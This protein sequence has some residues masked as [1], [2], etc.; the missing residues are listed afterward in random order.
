MATSFEVGEPVP[1]PQV[2][3]AQIA[4]EVGPGPDD[5]PS[6]RPGLGATWP[7]CVRARWRDGPRQ[8]VL[9]AAAVTVEPDT[10]LGYSVFTTDLDDEVSLDLEL[11][12][13]TTLS[14]LGARDEHAVPLTP[15]A[16]R[17]MPWPR[18]WN[19]VDCHVGAL[20]AGRTVTA[21][22]VR[23]GPGGDGKDR[24][25]WIDDVVLAPRPVADSVGPATPVAPVDLVDTRRGSRSGVG[26]SRGNTFPAA[27]LPN[28]ATLLS[29]TTVPRLDWF[30]SWSAHDDASGR[31]PLHGL[32]LSHQP[33]PW[34]GD[35]NPLVV[36]L[37]AGRTFRHENETARPHRYTVRLDDG[38]LVDA[39]PTAHGAVVR[40]TA[41]DE[42]GLP[43]VTLATVAGPCVVE[44]D[45]GGAHGWLESGS[46]LSVG[47]SRLFFVVRADVPATWRAD[48]ALD[49]GTAREATLRLATSLI[50]VDQA[51]VNLA[52]EIAD[53]G[54]DEVAAR[55]RG[56]WAERLGV[57][58]IAGASHDELVTA[59]SCLYRLNLYP[60]VPTEL[61]SSV[62]A[63]GSRREVYASPVLPQR[64]SAPERTGA[65]VVE[66]SIAVNHGFWDT[67]RTVWPLY[68]LL[69]PQ[70][71]ARLA[72]GFVEQFRTAGW[73][74]RWSS[75]GF[76][77]LMTGTSSDVALADLD[78]KGVPLPDRVA[79]YRAGLR[80]ATAFSTHPAVGRKD[81][82]ETAYRG[83]PSPRTDEPVS[84]A[85]EGAINDHA[86]AD[87][88]DR[89]AAAPGTG[90]REAARYRD[91]AAYLRHRSAAWVDLFD[92]ATGFFRSRWA[93]GRFRQ[94]PGEYDPRTWGGDYTE[95]DGWA[96]AFP[97]PHDVAGLAALV[98]G[99]DALRA[100]LDA[101]FATPER[102]DR[103]GSYPSAMHELVEAS[104]LRTG[105]F[106]VSNQPVHHVPFLYAFTDAPWRTGEVVHDAL[107]RLF[108]GSAIGQGYPGDED[109]GE[110][111]AWYLFAAT[112]LYPLQVGSPR[113]TLHAPLFDEITW[114]L[115]GGDLVVRAHRG[116][117]DDRYPQRVL[118]DGEEHTVTWIDHA[119]LAGGATVDVELGP[120]PSGWGVGH[121]TD[122]PSL[123]PPGERPRPWRDVSGSGRLRQV[124]TRR[125]DRRAD[126]LLD[127]ERRGRVRLAVGEALLWEGGPA[128][129]VAMYT[130][131]SSGTVDGRAAWRLEAADDGGWLLLDR[132]EDEAF[133]WPDQLRPFSIAHPGVH[134]RYRLVLE[135]AP[136]GGLSLSQ[137]ELLTR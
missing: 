55:A 10:W 131:T 30:Y 4:L 118:V 40:L 49:L 70:V 9:L 80:N 114:H 14:G 137:L 19:R 32:V 87:M 3:G 6:D 51:R 50:G 86:L 24:T 63:D 26:L 113:Y 62:A 28:G 56:A 98:G 104:L 127:D 22:V 73:V 66:G 129:P 21:V 96:F 46:R 95:A 78:A 17:R 117:P 106:A 89:L 115:P 125:R 13:G 58:E 76:A 102:A 101:F 107:R 69:Y 35:R 8:A 119:R 133:D 1:P 29:P 44:P 85:F 33:S 2:P 57:L 15:Q 67:Y 20:A 99:R 37:G 112:G 47:R 71:A 135:A 38:L 43:V 72:D 12:D 64:P 111:S 81:L 52:G 48:G 54:L 75:P 123:T 124:R 27:A 59:Y 132:R 128:E 94:A 23:V 91:E 83:V 39:A 18:Q 100:R 105:Q 103:P 61:S 45:P 93:D 42:G 36:G 108:G 31:T 82:P 65:Q 60:T 116:S 25:V 88:A 97:A 122:P 68:G 53:A 120:R 121:D 11:D 90:A 7:R 92:P 79:A 5:A 134:R 126:V 110:L 34:M 41:P 16:Q 109:D 130:L 74:A 77:D 136:T 84:W